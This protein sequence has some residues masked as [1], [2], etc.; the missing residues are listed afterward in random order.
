MVTG[1]PGT[2]LSLL[3]QLESLSTPCIFS[4]IPECLSCPVAALSDSLLLR[5][6]VTPPGTLTKAEAQHTHTCMAPFGSIKQDVCLHG[7]R[8][9]SAV[10]SFCVWRSQSLP[11]ELEPCSEDLYAEGQQ[12]EAEA[13][14][15]INRHT[16]ARAISTSCKAMLLSTWARKRGAWH[17]KGESWRHWDF[18]EF[19]GERQRGWACWVQ[20]RL[21]NAAGDTGQA[22]LLDRM[23][24]QG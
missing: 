14:S 4:L 6:A 1:L 21:Q 20:I 23:A 19:P 3:Q 12:P 17:Q 7:C 18:C 15:L 5:A 8:L 2:P 24:R 10:C 13:V 9:L 11:E 22:R 16:P